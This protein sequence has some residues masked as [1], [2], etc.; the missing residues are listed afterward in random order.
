MNSTRPMHDQH[1]RQ[2]HYRGN[3]PICE[4][5]MLW[6]WFCSCDLR[7]C[8]D[9]ASLR[10][11]IQARSRLSSWSWRRGDRAATAEAVGSH[12]QAEALDRIDLGQLG[13]AFSG[14]A[15]AVGYGAAAAAT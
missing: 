7:Q 8:D 12:Y 3:Y 15:P 6:G 1:Q 13:A 5:G 4:V 11:K 2:H 10:E 14:V 9:I